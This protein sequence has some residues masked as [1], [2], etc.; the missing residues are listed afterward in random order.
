MRESGE[1]RVGERECV[2]VGELREEGREGQN[3]IVTWVR[4]CLHS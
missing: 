4:M 1:R 3:E 2:C